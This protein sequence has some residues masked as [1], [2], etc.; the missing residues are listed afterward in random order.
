MKTFCLLLTGLVGA[1]TGDLAFPFRQGPAAN[2]TMTMP[3]TIT[4]CLWFATD[5]EEAIRHYQQVFDD[6]RLL[7]EIR[8]GEGGPGPQGTLISAR[9]Q[10]ADQEFVLLNGRPP[11][12]AFTDAAS[13]MIRCKDQHEIDKY[14]S[15]LSADGKPGRCGWLKDRFGVS[16]QVVPGNI[17]ELLGGTDPARAARVGQ[18]LMQM[19]KIDLAKLQAAYDGK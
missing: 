13:L 18:A 7:D 15:K 16:W 3:R 10:L 14:W 12:V 8:W 6:A 9:L 4:T 1:A 19:H 11:A 2:N 17:G 5:A